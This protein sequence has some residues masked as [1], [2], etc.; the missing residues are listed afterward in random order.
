MSEI[1]VSFIVGDDSTADL[2]RETGDSF[3]IEGNNDGNIQQFPV[4]PGLVERRKKLR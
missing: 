1:P 2:E 4:L 3:P